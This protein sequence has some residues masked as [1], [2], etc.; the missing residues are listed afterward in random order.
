M[1]TSAATVALASSAL[2]SKGFKWD[3]AVFGV[4][5][6]FVYLYT[7]CVT[8]VII[9]WLSIT[10]PGMSHLGVLTL[11]TLLALWCFGCCVFFDPGRVPQGWQPDHEVNGS[12][13]QEVKKK[14]GGV[15]YCQKCQVH[16]PPR[17]HHCSVCN[18]C[19][20][21]MDHHCP[22]TGKCV[23]H[24][25]YRSFFLLLIYGTMA[26]WHAIGLLTAHAIHML[27]A[28][29]LD[30]VVRTGPNARVVEHGSAG[31]WYNIILEGVAFSVSVP[32]GFAMLSLLWFHLKMVATNKTTIEWREGVTAQ[33]AAPAAP[34]RRRSDHPYDLGLCNNL[35]EILGESADEWCLPPLRPAP[36]GTSY[37]TVFDPE[38][39]LPDY[40]L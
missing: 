4:L 39:E 3:W 28:I 37:P 6:T 31:M 32:A 10:V 38:V 18:R 34:G 19:V 25:N 22:W 24:G 17:A 30:K 27:R 11:T 12:R 36:G 40:K 29:A 15:R 35:R 7:I 8:C 5:A 1:L 21:R 13:L 2:K 33:V 26:L 16:K 14:D 20:L 9:P 23:G